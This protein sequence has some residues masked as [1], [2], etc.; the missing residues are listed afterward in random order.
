MLPCQMP[1]ENNMHMILWSSSPLKVSLHIRVLQR[2]F[3]MCYN[4]IHF[5]LFFKS[6]IKA[7][8]EKCIED[9]IKIKITV[10]KYIAFE[11][12]NVTMGS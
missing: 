7:A 8:D 6:Q 9:H 4:T 12:Y 1:F 10:N 11:M 3:L 5:G 2:C